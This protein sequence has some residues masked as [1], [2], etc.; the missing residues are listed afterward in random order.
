M[1]EQEFSQIKTAKKIVSMPRGRKAIEAAF[2]LI[3]L[4]LGT[5]LIMKFVFKPFQDKLVEEISKRIEA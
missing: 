5:F 2:G 4:G 3:I 1:P